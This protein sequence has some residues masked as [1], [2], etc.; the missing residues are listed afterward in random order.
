[1]SVRRIGIS[2]S[3]TPLDDWSLY[4]LSFSRRKDSC[5]ENQQTTIQ[6]ASER[7]HKEEQASLG[8]QLILSEARAVESEPG[9]PFI[10]RPSLPLR[11]TALLPST[12]SLFFQE[13]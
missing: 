9:R 7:E 11:P 1:M 13:E 2:F 10:S 4:P 12:S 5:Y 6:S 3:Q 8:G